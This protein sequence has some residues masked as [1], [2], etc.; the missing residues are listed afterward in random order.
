MSVSQPRQIDY[1]K[2]KISKIKNTFRLV[3][4][5]AA[6]DARILE[7]SMILKA[8]SYNLKE[9]K[10]ECLGQAEICHTH[11]DSSHILCSCT[12]Y[13]T[14]CKDPL[15]RSGNVPSHKLFFGALETNGRALWIHETTASGNRQTCWRRIF[16]IWLTGGCLLSQGSVWR[17]FNSGSRWMGSYSSS[18]TLGVPWRPLDS[19]AAG[20][21]LLISS[22]D[23]MYAVLLPQG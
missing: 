10:K 6:C 19:Y 20:E 8:S 22:G 1:W 15:L 9:S 4:N 11:C 16:N 7:T 14:G 17:G 12:P 21:S 23:P 2:K 13:R 5:F 3:Y 18:E